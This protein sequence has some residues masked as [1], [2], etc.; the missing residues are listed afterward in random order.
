MSMVYGREVTSIYYDQ[1]VDEIMLSVTNAFPGIKYFK[2]NKE[3][4]TFKSTGYI[5]FNPA[6]ETLEPATNKLITYDGYACTVS[7]NRNLT[8]QAHVYYKDIRTCEVIT[9]AI[10]AALFAVTNRILNISSQYITQT[11]NDSVNNEGEIILVS[12]D[13]ELPVIKELNI[14]SEINSLTINQS[15]LDEIVEDGYTVYNKDRLIPP[16]FN[17]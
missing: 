15:F 12:F 14:I 2:S 7:R 10:Y 11:E 5:V 8:I 13:V 9:S 4:T 6:S 1:I 3:L 17:L 16:K